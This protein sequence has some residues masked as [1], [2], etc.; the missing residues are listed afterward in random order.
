[1]TL[2]QC[3]AR[4]REEN[5]IVLA[6]RILFNFYEAMGVEKECLDVLR[7]ALPKVQ[8]G[9]DLKIAS[10]AKIVESLRKLP[11]APLKYQALYNLLLDSGLRLVEAVELANSFQDVEV[12]NGF[13]RCELA[14]F[15]GEK[16]PTTVTSPS[17]RFS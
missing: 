9:I 5:V 3:S 13:Y 17:T 12:V 11:R 14:M 4:S 10:E 7:K 2:F 1:M 8:C 15:R 16:Q 6:L